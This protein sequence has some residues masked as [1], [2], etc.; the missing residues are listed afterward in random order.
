MEDYNE[1]FT[2]K[3]I[4]EV[5]NRSYER[6]PMLQSVLESFLDITHFEAGWIFLG[7]QEMKL[8]ADAGLPEAL[9]ANHKQP[10]CGSESCYCLSSFEKNRLDGAIS[11]LTCKRLEKANAEG[12]YDTNGFSHHATAPLQDERHKYGV[13]NVTAPNRETFNQDELDLLQS[14]AKQITHALKRIELFEA[15]EKRVKLYEKLNNIASSLREVSSY[16][17]LHQVITKNVIN[18]LIVGCTINT[19]D[20]KYDFGE[21]TSQTYSNSMPELDSKLEFFVN[22][23]IDEQESEFLRLL[24]QNIKLTIKTLQ[25][26]KRERKII[27][28]QERG[29]LAQ[30]LHDT[31]NQLLYSINATTSAL[32]SMNQEQ[33][34]VEP[35]EHLQ[36]MSNQALKE[37]RQLIEDKQSNL[38]NEGVISSLDDYA[39]Q[40][41]VK[42]VWNVEGLNYIQTYIQ[43]NLY[44][45]C[46]EAIHNVH[47]HAKVEEIHITLSAT[48]KGIELTIFDS[49][50]GFN[51]NNIHTSY[52]L[53]GIKERIYL[54]GG[55]C[56]ITSQP[57]KGTK[58]NITIPLQS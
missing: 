8:V 12:I 15:E 11:I 57:S 21:K 19:N 29:A 47:K 51:M 36:Q 14:I 6:K 22:K 18:E 16:R 5:L 35:I 9:E 24:T 10:M 30:D 56:H 2:L 53:K 28:L 20:F 43:E 37:M 31:V 32:K 4:A 49:G 38:I 48:I 25:L 23:K 7:Q 50:C 55:T 46:R 52:G 33:S 27:Q 39:S 17:E 13:L 3:T 1:I 44:K 58:I 54:L 34:L 41:G 42:I 40:L 45:V 26:K